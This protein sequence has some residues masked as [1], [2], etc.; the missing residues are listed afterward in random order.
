MHLA[1]HP[2]IGSIASF[3]IAQPIAGK[4]IKGFENNPEGIR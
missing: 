4:H 3:R 1:F 2:I